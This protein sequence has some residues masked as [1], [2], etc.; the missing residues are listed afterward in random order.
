MIRVGVDRVKEVNAE[1]LRQEFTKIRFRF[2]EGVDDF[3][4]HISA[5]ANVLRVLG[6]DISDKEVVKKMLQSVPEKLEQVAISMETLL[7]LN[8]LPI[9]EATGHLRVVEQRKKV[10]TSRVVDAGGRLLL[11]K[12]EWVAKMKAKEKG[13]PSGGNG[14]RGRGRG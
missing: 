5:L 3:I 6:D 1:R 7:D 10:S 11:T 14:D 13:S 8:F 12:E 2:S 9:E 4:I